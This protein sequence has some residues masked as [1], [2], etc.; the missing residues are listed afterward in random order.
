MEQ[1]SDMLWTVHCIVIA[2]FL[3]TRMQFFLATNTLCLRRF[4][5]LYDSR[6][7]TGIYLGHCLKTNQ[8]LAHNRGQLAL[9]VVCKMQCI[10]G[11]VGYSWCLWIVHKWGVS[12][13][14]PTASNLLQE[15]QGIFH[16]QC[17]KPCLWMF[18]K[19]ISCWVAGAHDVHSHEGIC[20]KIKQILKHWAVE[21]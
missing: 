14:R 3:H 8:A 9:F 5:I 18:L 13:G 16:R 20:S 2:L 15:T 1:S 21:R 12:D 10:G 11:F 4:L 19:P 17:C 7:G 6:W